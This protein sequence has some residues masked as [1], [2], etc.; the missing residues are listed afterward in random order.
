MIQYKPQRAK[1]EDFF[2]LTIAKYKKKGTGFLVISCFNSI[3]A[4][5][6]AREMAFWAT[7][8]ASSLLRLGA[9]S[10]SVAETGTIVTFRTLDAVAGHMAYAATWITS[11]LRTTA[12]IKCIVPSTT[13]STSTTR[14]AWTSEMSGFTTFVAFDIFFS[15]SSSSTVGIFRAITRDVA[16]LTTLV[17]RLGF[18]GLGAVS[19]DMTFFTTIITRRCA[20]FWARRSLMTKTT[21]V[22]T[23]SSARHFWKFVKEV[24]IF[25]ELSKA[26]VI[27][28][29]LWSD[30]W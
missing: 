25:Q 15:A 10:A 14:F 21:T 22:I 3:N 12:T 30:E 17:T 24:L 2:K 1:D 9:V 6:I 27:F 13:T 28:G 18:C 26:I 5:A 7:G 16:F 19:R 20:S 23:S 4:R 29:F 11:L 8:V